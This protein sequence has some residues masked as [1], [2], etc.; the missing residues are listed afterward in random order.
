MQC[1]G[2]FGASQEWPTYFVPLRRASRSMYAVVIIDSRIARPN[3]YTP[4]RGWIVAMGFIFTATIRIATTN[5]SSI[6]H[7]PSTPSQWSTVFRFPAESWIAQRNHNEAS[8][9]IGNTIEKKNRTAASRYSPCLARFTTPVKTE[10][11]FFQKTSF[12][13]LINGSERPIPSRTQEVAIKIG[14]SYRPG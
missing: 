12:S 2:S 14:T 4:T 3:I 7:F 5:T 11:S 10:Y 13:T 6:D 1:S 8:F 9:A